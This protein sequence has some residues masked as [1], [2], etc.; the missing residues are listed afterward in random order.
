MSGTR[1][2]TPGSIEP[3]G[4][5]AASR[6][7]ILRAT[8]DPRVAGFV[9]RH[10]LRLGAS[11]FVAG[12]TLDDCVRVLRSLEDRGF[13]TNTTLL[14]ER[15]D[16]ERTVRRTVEAYEEVLERLRGEGL[17]TYLSVKLSQLGLDV[18]EELAYRSLRALVARA[19]DHGRFVRVDME[20]SWRVD[21]T[22]R[23]YRRLRS[24]G[25][26]NVGVV[27][28]SYLYRSEEDL[29]QLLPLRPNVRI[30]K[31]AY[32]E[33]P[34]VAFP[35]KSDV[36]RNYRRLVELAF[37][38]GATVAVATHD[39]RMHEHAVEFAKRHGI[40]PEAFQFQMLYGVRPGL[41]ADLLARGYRVLVATPYGPDWYRYFMRRL[42]E[43]PANVAFVLR[44]LV[45]R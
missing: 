16:D 26:D 44:N 40:R 33:P 34:T 28:Q 23:I 24:E 35:R 37:L 15:V 14:G 13:L 29:R 2:Q 31:G 17:R 21:A 8:D 25:Y 5:Q 9:R 38:G 18:G 41:Q 11:R 10:G 42:A 45:R 6:A 4:I 20:E 3:V 32:L 7:L 22:L 39:E 12:E 30:V 27:L 43:R 36:D 1:G 19:A